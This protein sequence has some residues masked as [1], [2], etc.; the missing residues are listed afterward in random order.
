MKKLS[1]LQL[2]CLLGVFAGSAAYSQVFNLQNI[3][4]GF[5][6]VGY[7]VLMYGQGADNDPGNNIWNGFGNP[8]GTGSG[9]SFGG[10][11]PNDPFVPGNPGN[12][13]ANVQGD[14]YF[15]PNNG[16]PT[17]PVLFVPTSSGNTSAA[18]CYSDGTLCPITVPEIIAG[19][20]TGQAI[21]L[22]GPSYTARQIPSWIFSEAAVVNT[23]NPGAGT[24]AA[25]LGQCVLSNVPD[26]GRLVCGGFWHGPKRNCEGVESLR[27]GRGLPQQLPVGSGLR[28]LRGRDSPC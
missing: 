10:G 25:P 6:Y 11:L 12:P 20:Y 28:G 7:N 19:T 8:A 27:A 14:G 4:Q 24:A 16:T 13:Y 21:T 23:A 3:N 2:G 15:A 18:N 26:G 1:L 9:C 17:T 5:N 22:T